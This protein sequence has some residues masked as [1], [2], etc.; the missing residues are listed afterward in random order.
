MSDCSKH[1]VPEYLQDLEKVSKDLADMPYD[2]VVEFFGY[3]EKKLLKDSENDIKGGRKR[4]S[5]LLNR[6][7]FNVRILK[8]NFERI[9][10][11]CKPNMK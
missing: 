3:F 2:K 9:W 8:E 5:L 4:L 7:A 6:S 11:I 10:K 1:I